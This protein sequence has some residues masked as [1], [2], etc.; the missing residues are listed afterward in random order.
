MVEIFD[1]SFSNIVGLRRT[2]RVFDRNYICARKFHH[3]LD[4]PHCDNDVALLPSLRTLLLAKS[5]EEE[6]PRK[7]TERTDNSLPLPVLSS[8]L[9]L[10]TLY[11]QKR[12]LVSISCLIYTHT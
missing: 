12:I 2:P 6:G 4:L 5:E 3:Q 9:S 8:V 1:Y 10:F 7:K 11:Q